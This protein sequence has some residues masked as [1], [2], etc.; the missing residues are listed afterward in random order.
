MYK[1]LGY[2][3]S[4]TRYQNL[5]ETLDSLRGG[6]DGELVRTE[7]F[8]GQSEDL[9]Q[10]P[11]PIVNTSIYLVCRNADDCARSLQPNVRIGTS[12]DILAMRDWWGKA[13]AIEQKYPS[14]ISMLQEY[15]SGQL[16]FIILPAI[17]VS[18]YK[19]QLGTSSYRTILSIPFYHY[20]HKK[21]KSMLENVN[22]GLKDFKQTKA[23]EDF[24]ERYWLN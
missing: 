7:A 2:N 1:K 9:L 16:D 8:N 21:H 23:Y 12:L 20:M 18:A 10:V 13:N 14:T 24:Q 17:E 22:Q 11:E 3:I 15:T 4:V 19:E 6:A 5:E